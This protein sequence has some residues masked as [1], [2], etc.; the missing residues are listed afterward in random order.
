MIGVAAP[1]PSAQPASNPQPA[2]V[3]APPPRPPS[4]PTQPPAA[5]L[6]KAENPVVSERKSYS[7]Q[8]IFIN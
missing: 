3:R 7:S 5:P 2:P 1:P 4:L 6:Q 8:L